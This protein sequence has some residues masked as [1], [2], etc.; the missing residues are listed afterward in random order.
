M[1]IVCQAP[2][3]TPQTKP[4]G[5]PGGFALSANIN[6]ALNTYQPAAF[7]MAARTAF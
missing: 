7:A 4:P 5:S 2:Y 3:F 1:L 6:N